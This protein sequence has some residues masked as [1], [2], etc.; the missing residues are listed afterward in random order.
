MVHAHTRSRIA[1][2]YG[3]LGDQ[4]LVPFNSPTL[5]WLNTVNSNRENY[6]FRIFLNFL[7]AEE[8]LRPDLRLDHL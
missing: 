1:L 8:E 4:F 6:A 7:I 5:A 2:R 3:E